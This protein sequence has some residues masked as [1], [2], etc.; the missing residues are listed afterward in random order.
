MSLGTPNPARTELF[1]AVLPQLTFHINIQIMWQRQCHFEWA[2]V[3]DRRYETS[4]PC[5]MGFS[6]VHSLVLL[7]PDSIPDK[8]DLIMDLH[9][10]CNWPSRRKDN[11]IY[12]HLNGFP[13]GLCITKTGQWA[14]K[15]G[16]VNHALHIPEE[17]GLLGPVVTP[18]HLG[19]DVAS[20]SPGEEPIQSGFA[21]A[22]SS[23]P[24]YGTRAGITLHILSRCTLGSVFPMAIP[25]HREVYLVLQ[26]ATLIP[27]HFTEGW[28]GY[29]I[30]PLGYTK[31][32]RLFVR[33]QLS[34]SAEFR[35]CMDRAPSHSVRITRLSSLPPHPPKLPHFPPSSLHHPGD[36]PTPFSGRR[37]IVSARCSHQTGER[38]SA[39]AAPGTN[40]GRVALEGLRVLHILGAD[41]RTRRSAD[42]F[43]LPLRHPDPPECQRKIQI[44]TTFQQLERGLSGLEDPELTTISISPM[45]LGGR[46]SVASSS[47]PHPE[48]QRNI[49][50][51][52]QDPGLYCDK[53]RSG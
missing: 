19:V 6:M 52:K 41:R 16:F 43:L 25:V 21:T 42:E 36:V 3:W 17:L 49:Q 34:Q 50:I 8:L 5:R 2:V 1:C 45:P 24:R 20:R 12:V 33:C 23:G 39:L 48:C 26:M 11:M 15:L 46:I 37:Y 44:H 22:T 13:S 28:E 31:S 10:G 9:L 29:L 51:P 18:S 14:D 7:P 30:Y 32:R 27:K 40:F 53:A 38:P 47:S 4:I 35:P